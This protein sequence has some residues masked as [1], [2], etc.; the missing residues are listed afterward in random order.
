MRLS[1]PAQF[2]FD[3]FF[4]SPSLSLFKE[5]KRMYPLHMTCVLLQARVD[6]GRTTVTPADGDVANQAQRVAN[7]SFLSVCQSQY[8][9]IFLFG[10]LKPF[11]NHISLGAFSVLYAIIHSCV[12]EFYTNCEQWHWCLHSC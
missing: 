11:S 4:F 3:P 6:M 10:F 2:K 7:M 5:K 9:K 12:S 1:M 8:L